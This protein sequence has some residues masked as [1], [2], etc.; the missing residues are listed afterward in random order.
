GRL[1][2]IRRITCSYLNTQATRKHDRSKKANDDKKESINV[3]NRNSVLFPWISV[4]T[5][6]ADLQGKNAGNTFLRKIHEYY[7]L[8]GLDVTNEYTLIQ[9]AVESKLDVQEFRSDLYSASIKKAIHCDLKIAKEMDVHST[10][11]V[12]FFNQVNEE[13]GI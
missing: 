12:V 10:P 13:Q 6:A 2:I 1:F 9:C 4:A 7:F 11:A 5:K 3:W 8:K